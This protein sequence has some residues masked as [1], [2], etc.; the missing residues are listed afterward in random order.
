MENAMTDLEEIKA[1]HL[2]L[3][4]NPDTELTVLGVTW[5]DALSGRTIES[6][7]SEQEEYKIALPFF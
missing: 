5:R 1:I 4:S 2:P 7:N 3:G 6:G